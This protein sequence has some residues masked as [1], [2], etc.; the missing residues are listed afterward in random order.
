MNYR[1]LV[2]CLMACILSFLISACS[3]LSTKEPPTPSIEN[4]PS[5]TDI[6]LNPELTSKL[7]P[8]TL[9]TT[10]TLQGGIEDQCLRFE[11]KEIGVYRFQANWIN[12]LPQEIYISVDGLYANLADPDGPSASGGFAAS[13][14]D[15]VLYPNRYYIRILNGVSG[16][17]TL[18]FTQEI[19][20]DQSYEPN[21]SPERA[22]PLVLNT[23]TTYFLIGTSEGRDEDWYTFTLEEP[24]EIDF[25]LLTQKDREESAG[26]GFYS[27]SLQ[28][29]SSTFGG[30]PTLLVPGK[31]YL[32]FSPEV[33]S[34]V[35]RA[36]KFVARANSRLNDD[37][38]PNNTREQAYNATGGLSG[39]LKFPSGDE[40]W[41]KFTL[42]NKSSVKFGLGDEF[43]SATLFDNAG[44]EI[45]V[46]S[47]SKTY[48]LPAGTY[49]ALFKGDDSIVKSHGFAIYLNDVRE[50]PYEPNNSVEQ[51]IAIALDFWDIYLTNFRDEDWFKFT[52]EKQTR[53]SIDLTRVLGGTQFLDSSLAELSFDTVLGNEAWMTLEAGTYYIRVPG[54]KTD[55]IQ[56][57]GLRIVKLAP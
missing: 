39:S 20:S 33:K 10:K 38:E 44:K 34:I 9:G 19:P 53:L 36:V 15:V 40:D 52:L 3:S 35:R 11:I 7:E 57:Y 22:T 13:L 41:F 48:Y 2:R 25:R 32:R 18:S 31:Y 30:V 37:Y 50:D 46:D 6:E 51:A 21:N 54:S 27:S 4:C 14:L 43:V 56:T 16:E 24:T 28:T 23:P 8:V 49:Y 47:P 42:Q 1:L 55:D 5:D 29:I 12:S 26:L 45:T 17:Y